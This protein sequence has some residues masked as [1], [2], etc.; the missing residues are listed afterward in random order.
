MCSLGFVWMFNLY[1]YI[2]IFRLVRI[3][4]V[5]LNFTGFC[6]CIVRIQSAFVTIFSPLSLFLSVF[7]S[8]SFPL[9]LSLY[10]SPSFFLSLSLSPV[11]FTPSF[12]LSSLSLF[13]FLSL[14]KWTLVS[15]Q[16]FQ[17]SLIIN[18]YIVY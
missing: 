13:L 10:P 11:S 7:L 17:P 4:F 18:L 1:I 16:L 3:C 5:L 14:S 2:Y 15:N 9:S 8:L 6:L 12:S